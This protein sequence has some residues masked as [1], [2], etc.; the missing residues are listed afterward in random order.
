ME[1]WLF[2]LVLN[3]GARL[4]RLL[5]HALLHETYRRTIRNMRLSGLLSYTVFH[6]RTYYLRQEIAQIPVANTVT[7]R[8]KIA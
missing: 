6:K 3:E 5:S 4:V 1:V 8:D 2:L 7:R